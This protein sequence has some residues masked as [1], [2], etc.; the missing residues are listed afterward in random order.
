MMHRITVVVLALAL[1][2]V[3]GAGAAPDFAN[4]QVQPYQ[5]PKPAPGFALPGL[6]GKVTHLADLRGKVVLVF[7]WATW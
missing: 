7:F 4:L 2:T 1:L 6:D 5:P 3:G